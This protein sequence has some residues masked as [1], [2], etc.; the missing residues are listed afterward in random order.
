MCIRDRGELSVALQHH[1]YRFAARLPGYFCRI[2][3]PAVD[4]KLAA[5]ASANVVLVHMHVSGG[6]LEGLR[7]LGG[8]AGDV[9]CRDV[10]EQVIAVSPFGNG[11]M[12]LQ[13]A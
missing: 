1:A 8:Q 4:S 3:A 2:S 11:A 5:K 12:A 9:L 7:I 10:C 13:A 6:N